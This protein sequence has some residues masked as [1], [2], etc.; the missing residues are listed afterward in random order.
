MNRGFYTIMAAQFFSALADN[1]LLFAAIALLSQV[2]APSW[3]TPILQSFFVFSYIVLAPFVGAFADSLPK[4][5][6]MFISNTIKFFGC[7]AMLVGVNP[8]IAYGIVGFGAAAYSPA[9]YGILTE[10]LPPEK[11]V[12]AN[13]WIEGLTVA[14]IVLGGGVTAALINPGF[15]SIMLHLWDVPLIETGIDTAP[16][17]AVTI[18]SLIYLIAAAINLYIPRVPIDHKPFSRN[19][20]FLL[21]DFSHC[22]WLLWRD[23]LGQVSLA[24]TTLFWGSGATLRLIVLAWA[25]VALN[26]SPSKAILLTVYVAV[27]IA[28]GAL[29]AARL[30]KIEKAVKVLPVG[31][32]MGLIVLIMIPV[33]NPNLAIALL[34]IIGMMGGFFVV[35]MN[36][37]L[38]HRGHLLMGAGSSIAVQNFNENLSIFAML[39]LYSLLE[40]QGFSIYSIITVFGLML[41]IIMSIL[42]KT[43][44]QVQYLGPDRRNHPRPQ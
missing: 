18:I 9:K 10:Y 7:L 26:Y 17:L 35:P 2:N 31:I 38:Q 20:I 24:V 22:F 1:A 12:M 16:E 37:L 13:G 15:A 6:V 36:A 40:W 23:P 43:H 28:I 29:L 25:A 3:H 30:V 42:L 44:G 14:A 11:L 34:I 5:R 19:P 4:G 41:A 33:T 8:L 39:G 21:K 27:G 32:A